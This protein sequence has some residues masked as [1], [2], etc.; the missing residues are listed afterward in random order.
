MLRRGFLFTLRRQSTKS[1]RCCISHNYL[2]NTNNTKANINTKYI[3]SCTP[4]QK[5]PLLSA[6]L[7]TK[8]H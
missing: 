7:K 8:I 5:F 2:A 4:M 1:G 3:E 6:D